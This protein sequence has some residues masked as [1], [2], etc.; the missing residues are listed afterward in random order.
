MQPRRAAG[1]GPAAWGAVQLGF[2]G[3]ASLAA[4][5]VYFGLFGRDVPLVLATAVQLG[6][7]AIL[8]VA[9]TIVFEHPHASW[10]FAA[11]A[12]A[13]LPIPPS[14]GSPFRR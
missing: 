1:E 13:Y 14:S 8:T 7:A 3:A 6:A 10:T 2:V 11:V 12:S 5:T 9:L 4:G